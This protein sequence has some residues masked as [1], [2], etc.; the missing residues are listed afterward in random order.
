MRSGL[1]VI[2]WNTWWEGKNTD[3]AVL[4]A[5]STIV[6]HSVFQALFD[7]PL[8]QKTKGGRSTDQVKVAISPCSNP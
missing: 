1:N 2:H 3:P 6:M 4:L 7:F 8:V 5:R